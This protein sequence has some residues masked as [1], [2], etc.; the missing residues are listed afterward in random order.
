MSTLLLGLGSRQ[1]GERQGRG[2]CGGRGGLLALGGQG[3]GIEL[4]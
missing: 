3:E 2:T 1:N 4:L